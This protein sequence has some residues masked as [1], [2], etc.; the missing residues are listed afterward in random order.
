M[1]APNVPGCQRHPPFAECLFLCLSTFY[2]SILRGLRV[3]TGIWH[4]SASLPAVKPP[5]ENLPKDV[6]QAGQSQ[7]SVRHVPSPPRPVHCHTH[8]CPAHASP[9]LGPKPHEF[10][11]EL[12]HG[13]KTMKGDNG[14]YHMGLIPIWG[15]GQ[16]HLRA[17]SFSS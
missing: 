5:R 8:G 10:V 12:L 11:F 16:Q 9:S 3:V 13:A 2:A 17:K 7:D 6:C 15:L 14:L 1:S 4:S